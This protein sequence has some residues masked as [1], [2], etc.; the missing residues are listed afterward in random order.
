[1]STK[2]STS[3][4]TTKPGEKDV[5][6]GKVEAQYRAGIMTTRAIGAEHGIS[7][8]RVS[9]KA[10]E[11]GWTRDLSAKIRATAEAKIAQQV[12]KEAAYQEHLTN[13]VNQAA[14]RLTEQQVIEA[15]ADTQVAVIQSHKKG[16]NDLARLR[17]KMLAELELMTDHS[18]V[19]QEYV[20]TIDES[21]PNDNGTWVVDRK[22]EMMRA[23]LEAP[24]RAKTLKVLSEVDE[25]VRKGQR[26]A[27]G[28]DK[29][30]EEKTQVEAILDAVAASMG[31]QA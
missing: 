27:F 30:K 13:P 19:L 22:A 14:R 29:V 5:D 2:A 10:K 11:F 20:D 28:I 23:I 25:R 7:H 17:D 8:G 6:W 26:E 9:Q 1:M 15:N 18:Q 24:E 16:L 31:K 3:K 4:K 21:G 12:A